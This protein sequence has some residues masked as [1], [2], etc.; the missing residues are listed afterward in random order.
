MIM[1]KDLFHINDDLRSWWIEERDN[2]AEIVYEEKDPGIPSSCPDDCIYRS[3][4]GE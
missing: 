3:V 1:E 4:C 2:K